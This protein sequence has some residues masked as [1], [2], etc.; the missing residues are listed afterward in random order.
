MYPLRHT[1]NK[2]I[3]LVQAQSGCF[4]LYARGVRRI[5]GVPGGHRIPGSANK[6]Q[7]GN[8]LAM[9]TLNAWSCRS[10]PCVPQDMKRRGSYGHIINMIG[11]SGHRIPDG[12]QGGG[13][14]AAT[15]SAVK[16]I[17]EGLR[18][19]VGLLNLLPV[20]IILL[21]LLCLQSPR[22]LRREPCIGHKTHALG[23]RVVA[24]QSDFCLLGYDMRCF[25]V[26]P[27]Y[28][29]RP[30]AAGCRCASPASHRGSSRRSSSRSARL[31]T[32]RRRAKRR[33][34]SSACSQWTLRM[35]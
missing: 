1:T 18:Q 13:F 19:E 20:Q 23:Q 9:R 6:V 35:Q 14:Y 8:G 26:P 28:R 17:T 24:L 4:F 30:A 16:T 34:P 10:L 21:C 22:T 31:A 33:Q 2:H 15:K 11:L 27:C 25:P 32:Q 5:G 7:C 12:P 3:L 29:Y